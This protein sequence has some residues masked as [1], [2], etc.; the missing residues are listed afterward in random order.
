[1]LHKA[2][3][4]NSSS[5]ECHSEHS[6][7][8]MQSNRKYTREN[9][10]LQTDGILLVLLPTCK[11]KYKHES[12]MRISRRQQTKVIAAIG[13]AFCWQLHGFSK[14]SRRTFIEVLSN[15]QSAAEV[16]QLGTSLAIDADLKSLLCVTKTTNNKVKAGSKHKNEKKKTKIKTLKQQSQN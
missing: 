6:G 7:I 12:L 5:P 3:F 8:I 11:I 9:K 13:K 15:L 10:V 1:M 14:D 2:P 16:C 4:I